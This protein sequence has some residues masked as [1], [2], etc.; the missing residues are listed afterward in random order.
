MILNLVGLP[1]DFAYSVFLNA[2]DGNTKAVAQA[3]LTQVVAILNLVLSAIGSIFGI[4]SNITWQL[5]L[6]IKDIMEID[7]AVV[8]FGDAMLLTAKNFIDNV[9]YEGFKPSLLF[10]PF[11]SMFLFMAVPYAIYVLD[12]N[13]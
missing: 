6:W 12:V 3:P 11:Y 13:Q 7:L 8:N 9:F 5:I 1:A 2:E 4:A 10:V